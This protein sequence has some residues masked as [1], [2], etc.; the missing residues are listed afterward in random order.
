MRKLIQSLPHGLANF[1]LFVRR[2]RNIYFKDGMLTICNSDFLRDKRFMRAYTAARQTGSFENWEVPWRIHVL[3]WAASQVQHLDGDFVECGTD[4]GGT[5]M[6]VIK[7]VEWPLKDKNFYLLDTFSGL[8]EDEARETE[9]SVI[10]Y[11][12]YDDAYEIC[13]AN[14]RD[15]SNIVLVR[16][17]IPKTLPTV[18]SRKVCYL[19]IDLNAA[20]PEAATLR[21]FWPKLVTG[22]MVIFDDYGWPLHIEQKREIDRI[23]HE[24]G[25]QILTL[26]TG[27]GLIIKP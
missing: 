12:N 4:R 1:L 20:E 13:K 8:D 6:A 23:I 25:A 11:M 2:F 18:S 16:G 24:F 27:Q 7:Y 15:Y 9:S 19:H 10:S 3:T 17:T 14:F 26:P 22:A 21:Y 5:A